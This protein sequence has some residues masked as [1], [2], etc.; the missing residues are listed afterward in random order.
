MATA[1]NFFEAITYTK[2]DS[3]SPGE[4]EKDYKPFVINRMLAQ[5]SDLVLYANEMNIS[6]KL[7]PTLQFQFLLGVIPKKK[8]RVLYVERK[9]N[10]D[11]VNIMAYY[12]VSKDKAESYLRV[13]KSEELEEIKE[14]LNKGG[15]K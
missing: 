5:Y 3:F 12:N 11:I 10:E 15:R 1:K 14:R 2:D 4:L 9:T 7:T 8:R 6:G 13:L